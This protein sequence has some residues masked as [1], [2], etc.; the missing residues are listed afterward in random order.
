MGRWKPTLVAGGARSRRPVWELEVMPGSEPNRW[1]LLAV[2][3]DLLLACEIEASSKTQ[4]FRALADD[5]AQRTTRPLR[6][7]VLSPADAKTLAK[8]LPPGV[9]VRRVDDLPCVDDYRF[10]GDLD[11]GQDFDDDDPDNDDSPFDDSDFDT[12]FEP[13]AGPGLPE[14][15]APRLSRLLTDIEALEIFDAVPSDAV[16]ELDGPGL[17]GRLLAPVR[18]LTFDLLALYAS[19]EAYEADLEGATDMPVRLELVVWEGEC[20]S[21]ATAQ[22]AERLGL[23]LPG[24]RVA[25]VARLEAEEWGP[26]SESEAAALLDAIEAALAYVRQAKGGEL[27]HVDAVVEGRVIRVKLGRE[28][29]I[30]SMVGDVLRWDWSTLPEGWDPEAR[31]SGTVLVLTLAE[32]IA[33]PWARRLASVAHVR[34]AS[35]AECHGLRLVAVGNDVPGLVLAQHLP[36]PAEGAPQGDTLGIA[37]VHGGL[38]PAPLQPGGLVFA[39][40]FTLVDDRAH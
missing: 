5:I 31:V 34:M 17:S 26:T 25:Q 13:F 30:D 22:D 4:A 10:S 40:T 29:V 14:G 23:A 33:E 39:A 32:G 21:E 2:D 35:C 36:P 37:L 11:D 8:Y 24:G 15:L 28:T 9:E 16:F 1:E 3:D 7:L 20:V 19:R 27:E 38:E 18:D 12:D 6:I